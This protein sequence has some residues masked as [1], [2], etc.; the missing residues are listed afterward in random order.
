VL[1]LLLLLLLL[2]VATA[3]LPMDLDESEPT[4]AATGF[5]AAAAVEPAAS[6]D[7]ARELVRR[8]NLIYTIYVSEAPRQAHRYGRFV[9][10]VFAEQAGEDGAS[11]AIGELNPASLRRSYAEKAAGLNRLVQEM[12]VLGVFADG[13]AGVAARIGQDAAMLRSRVWHMRLF[14]GQMFSVAVSLVGCAVRRGEPTA[15]LQLD[16]ASAKYPFLNQGEAMVSRMPPNAM[17]IYFF[18][19][20]AYLHGLRREGA[21]VYEQ[22]FVGN[23]PSHAWTPLYSIHDFIHAMATKETHTDVWHMLHGDGSRVI[24]VERYL[25]SCCDAEFPT[26]RR[27]RRYQSFRNGVYDVHRDRFLP[28]RSAELTED[29]VACNLHDLEVRPEWFQAEAMADP[30]RIPTPQLD[31]IFAEQG[32]ELGGDVYRWILAWVLGRP[33]YDMGTVEKHHRNGV[34]LLGHA[35]SGKS[36]IAKVLQ[37]FYADKD[38]GQLNSECEPKFALAALSGKYIWFCTEVKKNF[39]LD[40][41]MLLQMLEGRTRISVQEKFK[42]A[43]DEEWN[44]PGLMAG[45]EIPSK[46]IDGGAGNSLVRR[47]LIIEFPNKPQALDPN[48]EGNILRELAAIMVKA[49]RMY[50][51]LAARIGDRGD[52]DAALPAYFRETLA[53]F[54]A[55]T[56]PFVYMLNNHPDL[57]RDPAGHMTMLELKTLYSQWCRVNNS[58][59]GAIDDDEIIRQLRSQG[60]QVVKGGGAAAG[61]A[62]AAGAGAGQAAAAVGQGYIVVGLAMGYRSAGDDDQATAALGSFA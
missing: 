13:P 17:L 50:R 26:I 14:L 44:I 15:P 16:E 2:F 24:G 28:Y 54:Q 21:T 10:E 11:V 40:M 57:H 29:V 36:T 33:Q 39:Q 6:L 59:G 43:R 53:R 61:R 8:L 35:G 23:Q 42:T 32:F 5:A 34:F 12:R 51:L 25:E 48:L 19:G 18:L 58:R 7:R 41:G 9:L 56:Q 62:G 4:P 55:K 45:N 37:R 49:N 52:M 20:Q 31:R 3:P 46:W 38:T 1:L 30:C 27:Q 60:L 22:R 47:M